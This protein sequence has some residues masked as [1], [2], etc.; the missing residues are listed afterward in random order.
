MGNNKF[1]LTAFTGFDTISIIFRG[2]CK[3][4]QK[5][6]ETNKISFLRGSHEITLHTKQI[7]IYVDLQTKPGVRTFAFFRGEVRFSA[8]LILFVSLGI[9]KLCNDP[10]HYYLYC[11]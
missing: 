1:N 11:S 2:H 8:K 5:P 3:I 10:F 9:C 7:K 4:S 6:S